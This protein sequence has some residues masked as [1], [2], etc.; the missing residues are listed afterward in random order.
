MVG[1]PYGRL[2]GLLAAARYDVFRPRRGP[3]G[4]L[5]SLKTAPSSG[6]ALRESNPGP[7]GGKQ[8]G[9]FGMSSPD[10]YDREA[11]A[12]TNHALFREV[13][14]RVK[15]VNEGCRLVIPMGEWI[16]EC[17]ND[18]CAER[19]TLSTNE[20]EAVRRDQARFFV[21]PTSEHVWPEVEHV[22]ERNHR[23][24]I[25][26]NIGYRPTAE[27]PLDPLR[28]SRENRGEAR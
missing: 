6:G 15:E 14:E 2:R 28:V 8:M 27:A 22:I 3:L 7:S 20:Y 1:E 10:L 19:I 21:A 24:W 13:N 17:A 4:A 12:A 25:V 26:P 23:Y 11:R 16:C 18:T 5:P 9:G